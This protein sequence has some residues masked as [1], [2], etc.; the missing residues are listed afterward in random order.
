[1]LF[2]DFTHSESETANEMI[3]RYETALQN[4]LDQGVV[5][6]VNM[7]QRILIGRPAERYK[8]LKQNFLLSPVATRPTLNALKAQVRDIDFDHRKPQGRVKTKA[9][10][11]HQAETEA[12]WGRKSNSGG[13]T[14]REKYSAR[15]GSSS[16]QGGRGGRISSDRSSGNDRARASKSG[17]DITCYCCGKK[18]HI[19]PDCPKRSE[20][21]RQ[22]GKVGHLQSMCKSKS[23]GGT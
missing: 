18:G 14:R 17:G 5:V 15:G 12:N 3:E 13:E 16:S 8:F 23:E 6:D 20:E 7:R 21:C 10:Q 4:C 19:K 1:M 9:G 22:C 11:G 2:L